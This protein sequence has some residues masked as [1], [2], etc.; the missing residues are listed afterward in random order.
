MDRIRTLA[1]FAAALLVPAAFGVGALWG[2]GAGVLVAA[3]GALAISLSLVHRSLSALFAGGEG[4]TEVEVDVGD[5]RLEHEKVAVL[6]ALKDLE[7]EK[8]VGKISDADFDA[9]TKQYRARAVEILAS[10]DRDLAP[11]RKKAEQAIAKRL[12]QEPE[13]ETPVPARGACV[14]CATP[15]DPDSVFCKKC[16][17]RVA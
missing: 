5:T 3:S 13:P 12:R 11:W 17:R 4:A 7:Y 6:R 15:L 1:P 16:G 2:A 14:D 10:I 9:L 8:A